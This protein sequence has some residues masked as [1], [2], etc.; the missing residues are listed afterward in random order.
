MDNLKKDLKELKNIVKVTETN[1]RQIPSTDNTDYLTGIWEKRKGEIPTVN[2]DAIGIRKR[3]QPCS[4]DNF[5][6]KDSLVS[7][8]KNYDG[9]G[10]VLRG[11][12]GTGKTH[13]AVALMKWWRERKWLEY[14]E[15]AIQVLGEGDRGGYPQFTFSMRF[16]TV[17]DLLLQIRDSFRDGS[18][19][20]ERKLIE[21]FA[22]VPFLVLDDLG[23]EKASEYAIT[24]L[25]I[26]IDRRDAGMMDTVITTNLTQAEIEEKLNARIAS[27]LA[28][29]DN[30]MIDMVDYRKVK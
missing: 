17:P 1:I 27:R 23:S 4:F 12:T 20:T 7:D 9:D 2:L 26:L 8:L 19:V 21:E 25:Y 22:N 6:G 30:K 3:Y 29:W 16:I 18:K 15:G 10:L 13:L 14:C 24:T 28:G 5:K 11:K